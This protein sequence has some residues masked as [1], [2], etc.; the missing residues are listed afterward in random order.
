MNHIFIRNHYDVVTGRDLSLESNIKGALYLHF[1][2]EQALYAPRITPQKLNHL[3]NI[4]IFT[5]SHPTPQN[6]SH[7]KL[8]V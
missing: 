6:G 7:V 8:C 4:Q 2:A 5:T 1:C 3:Q